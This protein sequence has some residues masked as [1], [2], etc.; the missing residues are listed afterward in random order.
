MDGSWL[1]NKVNGD[2]GTQ[3]TVKNWTEMV[4]EQRVKLYA[5]IR[6]TDGGQQNYEVSNVNIN[7]AEEED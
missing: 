7:F 3:L 5:H 6:W 2:I 1:V 4:K